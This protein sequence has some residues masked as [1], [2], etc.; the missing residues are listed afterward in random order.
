M[1]NHC[2]PNWECDLFFFF[3][4]FLEGHQKGEKNNQKHQAIPYNKG[5]I[6]GQNLLNMLSGKSWWWSSK[7]KS[8]MKPLQ[9]DAGVKKIEYLHHSERIE[10]FK[11]HMWKKLRMN[12]S[13]EILW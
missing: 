6:V 4:S 8:N 10:K 11:H 1:L 13:C 7:I 12:S 3:F 2:Y 9:K 5:D